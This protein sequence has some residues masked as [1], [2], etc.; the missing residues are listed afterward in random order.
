M[1]FDRDELE[2]VHAFAYILSLISGL[3]KCKEIQIPTRIPEKIVVAL[4]SGIL[5][6]S[7]IQVEAGR[8][9]QAFFGR[10]RKTQGEKNSKLKFKYQKVGTFFYIVRLFL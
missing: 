9:H 1:T 5:V 2:L 7:G 3:S 8:L 6:N 4:F 10:S